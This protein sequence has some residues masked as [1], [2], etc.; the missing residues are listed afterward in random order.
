MEDFTFSTALRSVLND[1]TS[2]SISTKLSESNKV[3]LEYQLIPFY[4]LSRDLYLAYCKRSW[5]RTQW[6]KHSCFLGMNLS[7]H[8]NTICMYQHD[9]M[10]EIIPDFSGSS[11]I[12]HFFFKLQYGWELALTKPTLKHNSILELK[13][14][15][16][17]S[18]LRTF[19]SSNIIK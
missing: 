8:R 19:C 16:Q 2:F 9:K 6:L 18:C 12:T 11:Y 17:N 3:K 14:L 1:L 10:W 13:S 15:T 5:V 7:H 4:C